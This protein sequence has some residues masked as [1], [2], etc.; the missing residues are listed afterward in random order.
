MSRLTLLQQTANNRRATR[1]ILIETP[2]FCCH[3]EHEIVF[4]YQQPTAE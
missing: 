2:T 4:V 3:N 1:A